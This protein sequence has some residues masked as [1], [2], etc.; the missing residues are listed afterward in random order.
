[1]TWTIDPELS[2]REN[3]VQHLKDRFETVRQGVDGYTVEWDNV[4]RG[5]LTRQDK[6]LDATVSLTDTRETKTA[7]IGVY[8]CRLTIVVE[9]AY[10]VREGDDP[11]HELNRLLVDV[12]RL[13]RTDIQA[14]GLCLNIV[15]TSTELDAEGPADRVVGGVTFWEVLYRHSLQDPRKSR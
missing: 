8:E 15:E 3:I 1:M 12:Q 7:M 2:K 14:G 13:M 9:F 10:R 4:E 5:P 11:L 6:I